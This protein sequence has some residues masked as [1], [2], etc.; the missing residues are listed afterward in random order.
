MKHK[1]KIKIKFII[2]QK[3][4]WKIL[5]YMSGKFDQPQGNLSNQ[6]N[7]LGWNLQLYFFI[8]S[9]QHIVMALQVF[10]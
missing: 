6:G 4:Q 9:G 5:M 8:L 1:N 7:E 3:T 2:Q 10:T